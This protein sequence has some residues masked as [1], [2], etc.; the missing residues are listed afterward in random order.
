MIYL[1]WPLFGA[2]IGVAAA[3][4][5][6]FNVA[7]GVL[8]G[9]LLGPLAFLLYFVSGIASNSDLRKKCP[10]CAEWVRPEAIVCPHC[11]RDLKPP[12]EPAQRAAP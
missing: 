2:L 11:Q 1:F 5:R 6:G 8:G 9:A 7:A 3:Q 4:K 12:T 10:F